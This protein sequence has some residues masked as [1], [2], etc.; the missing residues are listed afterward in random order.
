M[1]TTEDGQT[2]FGLGGTMGG[3]GVVLFIAS[4][5]VRDRKI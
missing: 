1:V 2:L 5:V 4:F 3:V